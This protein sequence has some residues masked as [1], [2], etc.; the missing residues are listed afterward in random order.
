ML[1]TLLASLG[2]AWEEVAPDD[3][4]VDLLYGPHAPSDTEPGVWLWA[5]RERWARRD[6]LALAE[7]ASHAAGVSLRFADEGPLPQ[8]PSAGPRQPWH[9]DALFD[10]FWLTSGLAE[11]SWPKNRVGFF[12]VTDSPLH[13]A[14]TF[15]QAAVSRFALWLQQGLA[16][17]S[18]TPLPRWPNG[19]VAAMGSHDVD[20]PETYRLIEPL[21]IL[22]RQGRRGLG[23]GMAVLTGR[24]HHWQFDSWIEAE[25]RM[26]MRS[27]FYFVGRQG[28]L[29]EYALGTP[30]PFYDVRRPKFRRLMAQLADDGFEV[31]MHASFNAYQSLGTFQAEK[32]VLEEALGGPIHG[33]RHHYWHLNPEDPEDSLLLH[34]GAGFTYDTSLA[35]EHTVGW[36]RG[37]S[38]PFFPYSHRERRPIRTLQLPPTWMDNHLFGHAVHNGM[39]RQAVLADLM[40]TT[41][42]QGG[43]AVVDVHE[44]VWDPVLFPHWAESYCAFFE[45]LTQR[46]DVFVGR[47]IDIARHWLGRQEAI[48]KASSGLAANPDRSAIVL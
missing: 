45:K 22:A 48:E 23:P 12:D 8:P 29:V 7:V 37:L 9:H 13:A 43:L 27:A 44:Y 6:T 36:R 17:P 20:Y 5:D 14:G 19:A 41:D 1:R 2:L 42:Q 16:R 24:R 4:G 40:E 30:D 21:R 28:S 18:I 32:A 38:W 25:R 46:Q 26:G 15:R 34:E 47:P 10:A 31:G 33:N 39:D 35:F 3:A 11:R